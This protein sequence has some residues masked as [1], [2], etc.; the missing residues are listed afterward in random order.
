MNILSGFYK[1]TTIAWKTRCSS[2]TVLATWFSPRQV[3][4]EI[5]PTAPSWHLP[6]GR[7]A[8]TLASP[9]ATAAA[10]L[11]RGSVGSVLVPTI[12][13]V[14]VVPHKAVAEVLKI[15]NL[16]ERLVVVNQGWQSESTDGP[17]GA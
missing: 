11:L 9:S 14:P 4:P 13:M 17:K 15:G 3:S 10:P 7:R 12:E 16:S 1:V 8:P 2:T 5:D 6:I